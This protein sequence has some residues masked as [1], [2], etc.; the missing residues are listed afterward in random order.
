MS[1]IWIVFEKDTTNNDSHIASIHSSQK[2]A[3]QS[4]QHYTKNLPPEKDFI[5]Y[6]VEAWSVIQSLEEV[7]QKVLI[8]DSEEIIN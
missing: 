1:T 2:V 3:R 6:E 8:I 7:T 4:A 5:A